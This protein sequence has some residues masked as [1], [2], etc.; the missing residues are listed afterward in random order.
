MN[1]W[2]HLASSGVSP[3]GRA[4]RT[5]RVGASVLLWHGGT[6]PPHS[7]S[8]PGVEPSNLC[9]LPLL[10]RSRGV[11]GPGAPHHHTIFIRSSSLEKLLERFPPQSCD[12]LCWQPQHC[13]LN[14]SDICHITA[15]S[16]QFIIWSGKYFFQS[17][18]ILWYINLPLPSRSVVSLSYSGLCEGS[19]Q[20]PAVCSL[21]PDSHTSLF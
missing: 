21:P 13:L 18:F 5:Y 17:V 19:S 12:G 10:Q 9:R 2:L 7:A 11:W 20:P 6:A 3:L 8:V 14:G 1:T 15:T 4:C 16:A